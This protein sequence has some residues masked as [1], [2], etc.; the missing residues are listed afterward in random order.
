MLNFN[1]LMADDTIEECL[2][3]FGKR[4]YYIGAGGNFLYG[5]VIETHEFLLRSLTNGLNYA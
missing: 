5:P 1:S 2:S 3:L 4:E